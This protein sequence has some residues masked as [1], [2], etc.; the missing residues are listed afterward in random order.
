[1]RTYKFRGIPIN[2]KDRDSFGYEVGKPID[3]FIYGDLEIDYNYGGGTKYYISM[4]VFGSLSYRQRIEVRPETVGQ[5]TGLK[6]KNGVEIYEM[7]IVCD[8]ED[9]TYYKTLSHDEL[10]KMCNR[11]HSAVFVVKY[12]LEEVDA[13]YGMAFNMWS[14]NGMDNGERLSSEHIVIGSIHD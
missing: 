1:M 14:F 12:G 4:E 2:K 7:D 8:D 3:P 10:L 13:F 9:V 6:D 5:F 11:E